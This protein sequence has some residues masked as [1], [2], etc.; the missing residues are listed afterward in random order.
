MDP[1]EKELFPLSLLQGNER[2]KAL[3]ANVWKKKF[4]FSLFLN[5]SNELKSRLDFLSLFC[6]YPIF[7]FTNG[8]NKSYGKLPDAFP[9]MPPE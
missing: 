3:Y 7:L 6:L 5:V 8:W 4:F 9:C 2:H 1:K